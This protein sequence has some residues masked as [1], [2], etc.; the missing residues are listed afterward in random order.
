MLQTQNQRQ[1]SLI[2]H[3]H[4][5]DEQLAKSCLQWDT[6]NPTP[7]Q[8]GHILD[9]S[10]CL[11]TKQLPNSPSMVPSPG[12]TLRCRLLQRLGSL[13]PASRD[14]GASYSAANL[15]VPSPQAVEYG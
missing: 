11:T 4:H 3:Q 13:I 9:I 7:K 2:A 6:Q 15:T 14:P 10:P 5:L 8:Q 1:L 12:M